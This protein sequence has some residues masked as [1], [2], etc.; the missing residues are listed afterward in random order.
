MNLEHRIEN[1]RPDAAAED[2]P[3][4]SEQ[5]DHLNQHGLL[6]TALGQQAARNGIDLART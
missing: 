5:L 4:S 1:H 2:D 6:L 3:C